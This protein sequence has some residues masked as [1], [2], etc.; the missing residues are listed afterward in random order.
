MVG[1][2]RREAEV[3]ALA[4]H[5]RRRRRRRTA[6]PRRDHLLAARFDRQQ[7]RPQ[8]LADAGHLVGA[9]I[10]REPR[11]R[12]VGD[13]AQLGDERAAAVDHRRRPAVACG[14]AQ[15]HRRTAPELGAAFAQ[16]RQ[17]VLAVLL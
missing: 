16:P 1:V 11:R 6:R 14:A 13:V 10:A 12:H 4:V 15:R 7:G 17:H 8:V 9:A 2:L 3:V 5:H